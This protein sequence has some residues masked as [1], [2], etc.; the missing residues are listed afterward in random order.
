MRF[1]YFIQNRAKRDQKYY[2]L[3]K[4]TLTPKN[5]CHSYFRNV[6]IGNN[7]IIVP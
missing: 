6:T 5:S 4:I 2:P 3:Y 7:I 1:F